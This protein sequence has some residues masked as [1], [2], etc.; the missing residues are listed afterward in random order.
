MTSQHA[1]TELHVRPNG[2]A[3][4]SYEACTNRPKRMARAGQSV[5]SVLAQSVAAH[6]R[7]QLVCQ[8]G[9]GRTQ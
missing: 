3:A 1:P 8:R 7:Q 5:V 2:D 4:V 9:L 6:T